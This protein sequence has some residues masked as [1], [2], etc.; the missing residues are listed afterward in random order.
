MVTYIHDTAPTCSPSNM[1]ALEVLRQLIV[2]VICETLQWTCTRPIPNH[3][4]E[5][6][7]FLGDKL[8]VF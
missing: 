6:E 2:K 4:L 1:Y 5:L 7:M 3:E 8:K